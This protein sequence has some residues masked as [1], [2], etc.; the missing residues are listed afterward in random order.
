MK[1]NVLKVIA[2]LLVCALLTGC[3]VVTL[4]TIM[5]VG[6]A[7]TELENQ[8]EEFMA[9]FGDVYCDY[10]MIVTNNDIVYKYFYVADF[11]DEDLDQIGAALAEDTSWSDTI[12]TVKDDIES[13]AKIRPDSITF[14]YY[15][16][17]GSKE[18]F[19]ITE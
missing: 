16:S 2:T 4:E 10:D 19:S 15:N 9:Q 5:T 18:V 3:G 13:S 14:A 7:K 11:T 17:D 6:D 8:R 1:K 12:N